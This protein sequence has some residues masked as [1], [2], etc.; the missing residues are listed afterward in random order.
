MSKVLTEKQNLQNIANSIRAKKGT[1]NLMSPS[2]MSGEIDTISGAEDLNTELTAQDTALV[3]Q[4]SKIAQMVQA[5]EN[6]KA[7][8][9][10]EATS[11][12]TATSSDILE[13]K[14][15]YVNGVKITGTY[16]PNE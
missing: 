5:L 11:D 16:N 15:A 6:K 3:N 13:G 14:T 10:Q 8:D 1:Q 12:A 7:I 4:T 2:Q 9:L